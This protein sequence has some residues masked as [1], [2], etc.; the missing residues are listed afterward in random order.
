MC[1]LIQYRFYI[2][3]LACNFMG[4]EFWILSDWYVLI[5]KRDK[6]DTG[7]VYFL[8]TSKYVWQVQVHCIILFTEQASGGNTFT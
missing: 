4:Q 5:K 6:Q 3:V 8:V 2:E 1:S 7:L